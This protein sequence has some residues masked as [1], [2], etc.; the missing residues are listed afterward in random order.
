MIVDDSTD[1]E[2]SSRFKTTDKLHKG[3]GFFGKGLA[4]VTIQIEMIGNI[5]RVFHCFLEIIREFGIRRVEK[6]VGNLA[7]ILYIYS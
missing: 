7:D 3:K 4:S 5:Q 6:K 1:V 2:H